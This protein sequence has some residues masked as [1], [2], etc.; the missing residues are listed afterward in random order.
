M[1]KYLVNPLNKKSVVQKEIYGHFSEDLGRCIYN[2]IY[3]GENSD[4]PN[5]NGMRKDI[6]DALRNIKIPVLRWPG[7]CFADEYHWKDGIGP[8][9]ERK[10]MIN[11]NWGGVVDDN[12]FGTH[13][14]M[15]LCR[16]LDCEPY[17]SVN[18]GSGTVAEMQE[19]I[20][21][22]TFDGTSPMSELRQK[23]G[24]KEPWKVKYIGVGNENWG[25]GGNMQPEYYSDVYRR[26]Q[27]YIKNYGGNKIFKIACGPGTGDP[28]WTETL[29]KNAGAFMDGLSLHHYTLAGNDWNHKGH[30]TG[31][32][33]RTYYD[34]LNKTFE[35]ENTIS[36]HSK[37]M[38]R[39]D[40]AK[41]VALI[42]DEWGNWFDVE[43][44]T[45]PGFLY[46]QNTMRDALVA[47]INLNIFNKHSDRVKMAN[48]AQLVNVLQSVALTE[49]RKMLLTPT[50]YVFDLYKAHQG[51]TLIDSFIETETIGIEDQTVPNL[52]ESVTVNADGEIISTLCNLSATEAYDVELT[53]FDNNIKS[54]TAAILHNKFN[55]Y[56]TFENPELVKTEQFDD[57]IVKN[58][59][60]QFKIPACSVLSIK[61]SLGLS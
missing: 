42:V 38:D 44:G 22:M 40:P 1:V 28:R 6:V 27:T 49:G 33:E 46:Q 48:I 30:A 2:G 20:E 54:A 21:Y 31:F 55:S 26:Y 15:E 11:S 13:E 35:M 47:G 9:H 50:Y 12:S 61:L 37:V 56:N 8:K 4:I 59:K 45:N 32:D 43:P 36:A 57:F 14:F 53:V 41:R 58:G 17:I 52:N 29:M 39:Y 7:G 51:G 10:K 24:K 3:V 19:W 23:N 60:L 16:Q 25:C 34:T 18:I 5:T